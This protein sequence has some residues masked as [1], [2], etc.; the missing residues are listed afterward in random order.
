MFVLDRA[1]ASFT[2]LLEICSFDAG[3]QKPAMQT[4]DI[5]TRVCVGM[6]GRRNQPC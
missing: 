3:P 4:Q 1:I 6:Q 5:A 2:S